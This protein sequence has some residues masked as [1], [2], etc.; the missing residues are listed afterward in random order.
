MNETK[1]STETIVQG[2]YLEEFT[3]A[4][5]NLL[6]ETIANCHTNLKDENLEELRSALW[7]IENSLKEQVNLNHELY[8]ELESAKNETIR[9]TLLNPIIGIHSSMEESLNY[10]VNKMP[11][12]FEGNIEGQRDKIIEHFIY[13]KNRIMEMF[14]YNH[15]LSVISPSE[16]ELFNPT[17]HSIVG[18]EPTNDKALD[19]TIYR[20]VKTGFK[21]NGNNSIYKRAEV[22]TR[23]FVEEINSDENSSTND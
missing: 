18:T 8:R 5:A 13:I 21:D 22:I 20:L 10:I 4:L 2:N 1:N 11:Q 17:E 3:K 14:T 12:D 23:M 9:R 7:N 19:N 6:N 15:G 16:G